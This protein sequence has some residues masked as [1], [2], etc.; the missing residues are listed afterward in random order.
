MLREITTKTDEDEVIFFVYIN[1]IVVTYVLT[2]A[3][4][5]I[6]IAKI[7]QTSKIFKIDLIRAKYNKNGEKI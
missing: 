1:L 4:L 7:F 5:N 2:I 3:L 6:I